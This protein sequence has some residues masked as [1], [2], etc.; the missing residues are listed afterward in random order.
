MIEYNELSIV[1]CTVKTPEQYQEQ[2]QML[3]DRAGCPVHVFICNNNNHVALTQV[4][5][6]MLDKN[7]INK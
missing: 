4:Y 5:Q 1:I 6:Q 2:V 7:E 3:Y